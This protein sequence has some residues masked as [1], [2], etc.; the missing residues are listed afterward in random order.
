ME[1][2]FS[3]IRQIINY[4][5]ISNNEFGRK[6]GCSS[7]QITQMITHEKN[8]GIDKLLKILVNYPQISAEWLTLGVGPMLKKKQNKRKKR[9]IETEQ[10]TDLQNEDCH[11]NNSNA[12]ENSTTISELLIRLEKQSEIIGG[13]KNENKQLRKQLAEKNANQG[14]D[15]ADAVCATTV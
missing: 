15:A 3:R 13:L 9:R 4:Y 8:F 2:I 1:N 7:A 11:N 14:Q 10:V 6:I 5:G 12:Q